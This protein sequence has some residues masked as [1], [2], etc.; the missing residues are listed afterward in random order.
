MSNNKRKKKY[1][2]VVIRNF[3]FGKVKYVYGNLF[4]TND[5]EQFDNLINNKR[6]K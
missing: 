3:G 6:I 4:E 1:K 2:G 5:K